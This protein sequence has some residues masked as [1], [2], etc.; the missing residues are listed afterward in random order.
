MGAAQSSS[1]VQEN[2]AIPLPIGKLLAKC[3]GMKEKSVSPVS[4]LRYKLGNIFVSEIREIV[5]RPFKRLRHF[6]GG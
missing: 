6:D 3:N 4:L 1:F 2:C 5:N